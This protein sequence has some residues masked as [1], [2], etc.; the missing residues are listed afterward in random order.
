[1][2]TSALNRLILMLLMVAS[3][4]AFNGPSQ[5]LWL[6]VIKSTHC[7]DRSPHYQMLYTRALVSALN[8]ANSHNTVLHPVLIWW[9]ASALFPDQLRQEFPE[10]IVVEHALSFVDRLP[11]WQQTSC[12]SGAYLRLDI[13]GIFGS[14]IDIQDKLHKSNG[15]ISDEHILYTDSDGKAIYVPRVP[16]NTTQR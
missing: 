13:P 1:M 12:D 11:D 2:T 6:A 15:T 3:T 5:I 7:E 14:N 4:A 10:V 8:V 9:G 16:A